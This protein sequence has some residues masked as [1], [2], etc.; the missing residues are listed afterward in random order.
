MYFLQ[1]TTFTPQAA[2]TIADGVEIFI[3]FPK[4]PPVPYNEEII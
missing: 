4:S 3:V 1:P 2:A